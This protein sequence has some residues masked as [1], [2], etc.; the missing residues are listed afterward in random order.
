MGR[1]RGSAIPDGCRWA[2]GLH[3]LKLQDIEPNPWDAR[4]RPVLVRV[5]CGDRIAPQNAVRKSCEI[6]LAE[7]FG[8]SHPTLNPTL[9]Q[10]R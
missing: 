5:Q 10:A 1:S 7:Q 3:A 9:I 6:F 8:R 2:C 4:D